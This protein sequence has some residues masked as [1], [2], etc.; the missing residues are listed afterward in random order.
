MAGVNVNDYQAQ[1]ITHNASKFWISFNGKSTITCYSLQCFFT[2]AL[3][4]I[5]YCS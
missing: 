3:K 4:E 5:F 1:A 2:F